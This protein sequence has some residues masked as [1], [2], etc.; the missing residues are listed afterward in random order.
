[1]PPLITQILNSIANVFTLPIKWIE[2]ANLFFY[3][4]LGFWGQLA[5]DLVLFYL[6]F[7]IAFKVT[8]ALFDV[9]FYVIVPSLV[10]SWV[11][12]FALPFAFG[13]I[14][15]VCVAALIVINIFRS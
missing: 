8:K 11:S 12:S 13:S 5:F 10:L 9:T 15:P 3:A 2:E 4:H 1:M 14:L 7:L 6:L